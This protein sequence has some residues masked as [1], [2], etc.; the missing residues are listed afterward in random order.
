MFHFFQ[1]FS[2]NFIYIRILLSLTSNSIAETVKTSRGRDSSAT[3]FRYLLCNFD[4][5]QANAAGIV[6][7]IGRAAGGFRQVANADTAIVYKMPI[8]F[9]HTAP[10]IVLRGVSHLIRTAL[11]LFVSV[12]IRLRPATSL[13]KA[14]QHKNQP[15]LRITL[16]QA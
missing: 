13:I 3:H 9:L 12:D 4:N 2:S 11:D 5:P 6:H 14:W 16:P 10:K 8:T 7:G 1:A 15:D